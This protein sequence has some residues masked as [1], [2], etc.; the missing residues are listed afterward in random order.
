MPAGQAEGVR[1]TAR[2]RIVRPLLTSPEAVVLLTPSAEVRPRGANHW[3]QDLASSK[4]KQIESR[5]FLGGV[6]H[7][8]P[9][10]P[11]VFHNRAGHECRELE[12]PIVEAVDVFLVRRPWAV[13]LP[14]KLR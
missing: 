5:L 1:R 6:E 8:L 9:A 14:M 7:W 12:E 11:S 3:Q 10:V 13:S 4:N 2:T